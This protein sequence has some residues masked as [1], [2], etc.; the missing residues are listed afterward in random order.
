MVQR[1]DASTARAKRARFAISRPG[2]P[3]SRIPG[4]AKDGRALERRPQS[5]EVARPHRD[6]ASPGRP[7]GRVGETDQA[8]AARGLEE[9]HDDGEPLVADSLRHD[10]LL[11]ERGR[12]PRGRGARRLRRTLRPGRHAHEART[13]PVTRGTRL[14]AESVTTC[15]RRA[16]LTS[17]PRRSSAAAARR[18]VRRRSARPRPRAPTCSRRAPPTV[19]RAGYQHPPGERRRRRGRRRACSTRSS[20]LRRA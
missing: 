20:P 13:E 6:G 9:L 16:P 10:G 15:P 14:R 3:R 11:D 19:R 8:L 17:S 2:M 4:L 1:D 5:L 12:A 7:V 18:S